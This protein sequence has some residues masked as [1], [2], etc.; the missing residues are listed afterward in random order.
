MEQQE[1]IAEEK[2][3]RWNRSKTR[4]G[5][6]GAGLLLVAVGAVWIAD[7]SDILFLPSWVF[8]FPMF[9]ILV[10]LFSGIKNSFRDFGWLFPVVIGI[11]FL[12]EDLLPGLTLKPYLLPA[13]LIIFGLWVIFKPKSTC[14][15]HFKKQRHL[16]NSQDPRSIQFSQ[17]D[18]INGSAVF[19]GIK[20]SVITKEFKG[21]QISTIFGGAEFNLTHA[22]FQGEVVLDIT[23]V[24]GGVSLKIPSDW[25]VRS[26]I[27]PIFGG[28]EEKR[29]GGQ[30]M[31]TSEKILVLRGT[32]L[33]GGIDIKSY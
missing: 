16:Q 10:G 6:I 12:L 25:R 17:E 32:L 23:I 27:S 13:L 2:M 28:I 19:G 30:T 15:N 3:D 22:D 20:K 8:S 5:R 21:G 4:S 11:V 14:E 26:E 18:F 31:M 24:C 7:K 1:K 9:L 29:G 33:F